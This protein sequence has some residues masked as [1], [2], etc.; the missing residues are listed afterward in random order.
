MGRLGARHGFGDRVTLSMSH[1][2]VHEEHVV[3]ADGVVH[4]TLANRVTEGR[5]R[6]E[7]PYTIGVKPYARP[8]PDTT[9]IRPMRSTK[10]QATCVRCV[11]DAMVLP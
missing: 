8:W 9:I 7:T 1:I 2:I 4:I 6:C 3:D 5:T 11:V 10:E